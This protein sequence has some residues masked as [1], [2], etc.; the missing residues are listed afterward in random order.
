MAFNSWKVC[1]LDVHFQ[2]TT[3]SKLFSHK[4][5][6]D[7]NLQQLMLGLWPSD[8]R[9]TAKSTGSSLISYANFKQRAENSISDTSMSPVDKFEP[10]CT[11]V[12]QVLR[13]LSS[14]N[15][16]VFAFLNTG[17]L[18]AIRNCPCNFLRA[19]SETYAIRC[20]HQLS[21]HFY[22]CLFYINMQANTKGKK[23]NLV[24]LQYLMRDQ[25]RSNSCTV[26]HINIT[27]LCICWI[28][29][30]HFTHNLDVSNNHN[31]NSYCATRFW[32]GDTW[33]QPLEQLK[34]YINLSK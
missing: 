25:T 33:Q 24:Y 30:V 20:R 22:I 8:L 4:W 15:R 3:L 21:T 14:E 1:L 2:V 7:R 13:D 6:F 9:L 18:V 17:R 32:H 28:A 19:D 5:R 23:K 10:R 29:S 31:Y 27:S 16:C 34:T 12:M 11:S 26:V